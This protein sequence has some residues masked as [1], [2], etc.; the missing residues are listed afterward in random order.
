MIKKKKRNGDQREG[1]GEEK[2]VDKKKKRR[3]VWGI[4]R[5]INKM[6]TVVISSYLPC[7][8]IEDNTYY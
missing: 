8:H 3:T 5:Y 1:L 4:L 7:F 2:R 6:A